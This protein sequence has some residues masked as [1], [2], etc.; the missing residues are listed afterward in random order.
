M[1]KPGGGAVEPVELRIVVGEEITDNVFLT[2]ESGLGALFGGQSGL[3]AWAVRLE[4]RISP[5]STV[6][7]GSE[8]VQ[9]G[10]ALRGVTVAR[11]LLTESQP[12]QFTFDFKKRWSW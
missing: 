3:G 4:W 6:R 1:S 11:P 12:R 9:Q 10:R 8:L 7:V 2:V 5:T